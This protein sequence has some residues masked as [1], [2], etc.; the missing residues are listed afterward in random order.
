MNAVCKV[1]FKY[2]HIKTKLLV[3]ALAYVFQPCQL[4]SSHCVRARTLFFHNVTLI[5]SNRL[6]HNVLSLV[7]SVV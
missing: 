7:L 2:S 5:R 3:G 6:R 1:I 4:P